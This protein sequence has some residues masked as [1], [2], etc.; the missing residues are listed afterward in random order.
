MSMMQDAINRRYPSELVM[1]M[2][3][4]D[5]LLA[6]MEPIPQPKPMYFDYI[7]ET[8]TIIDTKV[9]S[10]DPAIAKYVITVRA[11]GGLLYSICGEMPTEQ[12]A[13]T[14]TQDLCNIA[15]RGYMEIKHDRR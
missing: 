3:R 7:H 10:H 1:M 2:A 6:E 12:V 14:T 11:T 8:I 4:Q 5:R 15:Y 9:T 13:K